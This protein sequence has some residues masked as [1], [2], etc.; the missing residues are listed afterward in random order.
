MGA[1]RRNGER[2]AAEGEDLE[3]HIRR[4][5]HDALHRGHRQFRRQAYG[6]RAARRQQPRGRGIIDI[7]HRPDD[8]RGAVQHAE[9][10]KIVRLD[11]I[12]TIGDQASQV[13]AFPLQRHQRKR[14]Q[15]HLFSGTLQ[16]LDDLCQMRLGEMKPFGADGFTEID[17]ADGRFIGDAEIEIAPF[18]PLPEIEDRAERQC[19]FCGFCHRRHLQ[20][21]S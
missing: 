7:H 6:A 14:R 18:L 13:A 8:M 19:G 16:P 9:R 4:L 17:M 3:V 20:R 15:D 1:A 5:R 10:G 2:Q 12:G 21:F 11:G